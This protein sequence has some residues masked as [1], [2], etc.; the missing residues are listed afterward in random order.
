MGRRKA[1]RTIQLQS[2]G[3]YK[4]RSSTDLCSREFLQQKYDQAISAPHPTTLYADSTMYH[5]NRIENL[6]TEYVASLL[7]AVD[8]LL[9]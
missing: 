2:G 3:S 6:F 1:L 9:I 8:H 4:G 5:V 7:D